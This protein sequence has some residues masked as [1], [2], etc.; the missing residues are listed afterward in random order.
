MGKVGEMNHKTAGEERLVVV[1]L[2][3][4]VITP[5]RRKLQKAVWNGL[6]CSSPLGG[7]AAEESRFGP[8]HPFPVYP[9]NTC[10]WLRRLP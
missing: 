9:E 8:L 4:L 5:R 2:V 6:P 7:R 10:L 1:S 3:H